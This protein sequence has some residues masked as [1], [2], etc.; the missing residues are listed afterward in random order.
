MISKCFFFFFVKFASLEIASWLREKKKKPKTCILVIR[1]E[2][3]Q[4]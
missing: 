4:E 2:D 3:T 1:T